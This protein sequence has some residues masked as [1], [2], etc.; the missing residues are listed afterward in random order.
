M[1]LQV[2]ITEALPISGLHHAAVFTYAEGTR[3]S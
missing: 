2:G 1:W 3:L